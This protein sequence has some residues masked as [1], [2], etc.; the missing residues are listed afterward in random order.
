MRRALPR[1]SAARF[2]VRSVMTLLL[3]GIAAQE[4]FG[5]GMAQ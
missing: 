5:V 2:C 4:T 1:R 3:G